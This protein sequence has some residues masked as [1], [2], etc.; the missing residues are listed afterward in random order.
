M[1][2]L[3]FLA[4][5]L[6]VPKVDGVIGADEW[7]DATVYDGMRMKGKSEVFPAKTTTFVMS[8]GAWTYVAVKSAVPAPGL[9]RRVMPKR[10]GALAK[11]D[12]AVTLAFADG[13]RLAVNANGAVSADRGD[14]EGLV[15]ASTVTNGFWVFECAI[16]KD[17]GE[18]VDLGR[19]WPLADSVY[20][21]VTSLKLGGSPVPAADLPRLQMLDIRGG[22]TAYT[23]LFRIVNP[24]AKSVKVDVVANGG[25]EHSQPAVLNKTVTV[26]AGGSEDFEL[27]GAILGDE[28]VKLN[29]GYRV[30]DTQKGFSRTTEIRPN[31]AGSPF[32]RT[33]NDAELVSYKFAYY[34]SANKFRVKT[35]V[36]LIP[37]FATVVKGIRCQGVDAQGN[38]V[39]AR[40]LR[41]N[42]K[43][44]ADE[45]FDVPDLRP[46]TVKSGNP[47]YRLSVTVEGEGLKD[48]KYE[49]CFYRDAMAWEG[50]K[51]GLSD[52]VVP[53]FTAI[54]VKE[55]G[56]GT[57][58]KVWTVSTVLREHEMSSVGLFRQVRGPVK[59][60]AREPVKP[61]LADEGMRLVATIG[62][63]NIPIAGRLLF[64][65][66][67]SPVIRT[68][69]ATFDEKGLKGHVKGVFEY[70]GQLAWTLMLE[71]GKV[72]ALRLVIPFAAGAAT[73]VHACVD[74]LR[75]NLGARV[76]SGTGAVWTSAKQAGRDGLLGNYI[77]YIWVGGTLRGLAVYG[78]N[79]R[80]WVIDRAPCQEIVRAEDGMVKLI[81]NLVQRP[82]EVNE[83]REIRL[84]F[85]A[86][87]V[88]PM[89]ENWRANPTGF[90]YG[91]GWMWGAGPR[92]ADVE[93]FDGTDEFWKMMARARDT[94]TYDKDY[95]GDVIR[96]MPVVGDRESKDNKAHL[97]TLLVHYRSGLD[98]A[99]RHR[100]NC[101]FI[102]YTNA[103]GVDFGISSG[104]TFCDEWS[105][106]EFM[107][108][109]RDFTRMSSR[110]YT[111]DPN[112]AFQDYAVYWY[113]KMVLSTACDALYWDDIYLSP[114]YDLVGTESYRLP[115]GRIQPGT[116]VNN[117]RALVKRCATMQAELGLVAT[118]NWIHMTD[119][120]IAP[121]SA[122]AG[123]HYDMEDWP[124]GGRAFQE[125][126]PMDY[127]EAVSIGRQMGCRVQV[128]AHYPNI[129]KDKTAWYERT[130]AGMMLCYEFLWKYNSY[131]FNR[132]HDKLKAWGYRTPSVRVWNYWN[133]DEPYPLAV[134]REKIASIAMA[135]TAVGEAVFVVSDF[136]GEGGEV[137]VGID[138]SAF[139]L[140]AG[141]RAYDFETG[142]RVE[143]AGNEVVVD[144]K[145]YD[146]RVVQLRE[147]K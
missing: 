95:L 125:K 16:P 9:L 93:P 22:S 145:P 52:V 40:T 38:E 110:D 34:P 54:G 36:S 59:E 116:G 84:G 50:N 35:D 97:N 143:K 80:G 73:H 89:L 126:Y 142:E 122:F 29:V 78:E 131:V 64:D 83:P 33:G 103:R 111:L 98:N 92:D 43:G 135:K 85:M 28:L 86:T 14:V 113:R 118:D 147:G 13:R 120:A 48:V 3:V 77:P 106:Y 130:G 72:D 70:D 4:V 81:L 57:S 26:A 132:V 2:S 108:M 62:G 66:P 25:P 124:L 117:M 55:K 65:G 87:P 75:H 10:R 12:D 109:D 107:E 53:P 46:L 94:G 82:F 1:I 42:A 69:T 37:G 114:N 101:K 139:G 56:K 51:I 18:L 104:R 96:R 146:F 21:T 68:F 141:C 58:E 115:D 88:K 134:K 20:G 24:T 39:F 19:H 47:E 61:I 32:V 49:K 8:D 76:P 128:M 91:S 44:V 23:V 144:V 127:L 7:K 79:D 105:R 140:G 71:R 31:F 45:T 5:A 121:I 30:Q 6:A 129:S 17:S 136:T 63:K 74:N 41:P 119:T 27:K 133:G 15:T 99:A 138:A 90:L 100:R 60:G 102:W 137:R 11:I 123:V 112:R 67:D